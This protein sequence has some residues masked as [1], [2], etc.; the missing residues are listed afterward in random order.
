MTSC[1]ESAKS[2]VAQRFSKTQRETPSAIFVPPVSNP[3]QQR[4]MPLPRVTILTAFNRAFREIGEICVESIHKYCERTGMKHRE[5]LIPEDWPSHPSWFK[6][7]FIKEY[8]I[9]ADFVLWID[10][11][12]LIIDSGDI[13]EIINPYVT[14]N[15]AEDENG[16]NGGV[17]LWK[18]CDKAFTKLNEIT[19]LY[20]KFKDHKW[21]EQAPIQEMMA[22]TSVWDKW[23][24]IQ[25]KEVWNA[26]TS[27]L[28]PKT[29]II[30]YPGFSVEDK[31]KLMQAQVIAVNRNGHGATAGK[32]M[33]L[34]NKDER[35]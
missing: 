33:E 2:A 3:T 1:L 11:D 23:W 32:Y 20:E 14:L 9:Q 22:K 34:E 17:M 27:D 30:H 6:V 7:G 10:A 26:Y 15:I 21:F 25:P 16:V 19:S 4:V 29:R 28:C 5:A 12:A 8:L 35:A 24:A 13:R 31:L 18:N